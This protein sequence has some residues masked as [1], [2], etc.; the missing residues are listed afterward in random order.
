[1]SLIAVAVSCTLLVQSVPW[2]QTCKATAFATASSMQ[3]G[4]CTPEWVP[5]GAGV[6]GLEPNSALAL[7]VFDDGSGGGPALYAGGSFLSAG[8]SP[9]N[10][11]ARWD[12]SAWAPVGAGF[13]G[14]VYALTVFDDG[15]GPALYA[16]GTFNHVAR[17]NGSSWAKLGQGMDA[18]VRTLLG[19]DDGSGPA[20]YA[21]GEFTIADGSP[22]TYIARWKG[23]GWES[24]GGGMTF[25]VNAFAIH[26]DGSGAGPTLYAGGAFTN[27][28]G[29]PANRV[30]RWSGGAWSPLG[31]GLN[32]SVLALASYD[33][34]SG[35]GPSLVVGGEFTSAGGAV[36]GRLAKWQSGAWSLVG[37]HLQSTV[38]ALQVYDD[39]V[40][41]EPALYA[42]GSFTTAAG[43]P[44]NRIARWDGSV[45]SPLSTGVQLPVFALAV[46]DDGAGEPPALYAGGGFNSAGGVAANGIARWQGCSVCE[47]AADI[48][49]DGAVD[50]S[51]LGELLAQWGPCA[52]CPADLNGDGVVDGS[53]LGALLGA[54]S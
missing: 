42:G 24:V 51:D 39:G 17:W 47:D 22:A 8:G 26:D 41:D 52:G 43:V 13:N 23:Q 50:G 4:T 27:A 46:Y 29:N 44:V 5:G 34:G 1:M 35:S 10:Q 28:G 11:I 31:L 40:G 9:V 12:G 18:P 6:P 38:R 53:D 16:G 21:G 33:D 20:L 45:W 30:A 49:C 3:G 25:W 36:A 19:Y 54:W 32:N 7:A 48:N 2:V 37:G 15:S 14:W